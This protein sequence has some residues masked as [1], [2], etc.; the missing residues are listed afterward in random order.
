MLN[1]PGSTTVSL[2]RQKDSG[3]CCLHG[4]ACHRVSFLI[5]LW[6]WSA[7]SVLLLFSHSVVS[8]S[9]QL[10]SLQHARL[11]C[12]LHLLELA[13]IHGHWVGDAIRLSR[14]LLS[15]SPPAFNLLAVQ[16]TLKSLLQHYSSKAS[17]HWLSFLYGPKFTSMHDC[18][19]N[20]SFDYTDLFQ[21]CDISAF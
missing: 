20:H 10:H 1:N 16:G 14:L 21:Q 11:P 18:W 19:K 5:S 3:F 7:L 12:P 13:Q 15:P 8:N 17:V 6:H 4:K 9:L 2:E